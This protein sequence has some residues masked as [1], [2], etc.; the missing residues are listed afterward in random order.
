MK[1]NH[2]TIQTEAFEKE[3]EFYQK[4]V[5][6]TVSRDMRP[7]GKNIVFL[8][9]AADDTAIEI[10]EKPGASDAGNENIS[11][12]FHTNDLEKIYKVTSKNTFPKT[13]RYGIIESSKDSR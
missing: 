12:G 4:Y 13:R 5:G 11:I 1:L 8:S 6:L 3:I 2:I 10:I 9:G 7:M